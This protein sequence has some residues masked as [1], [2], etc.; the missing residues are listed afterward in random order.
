MP[1]ANSDPTELLWMWRAGVEN[2]KTGRPAAS[3]TVLWEADARPRSCCLPQLQLFT[4]AGWKSGR[5]KDVVLRSCP[6]LF[7]PV[8]TLVGNVTALCSE[9]VTLHESPGGNRAIRKAGKRE[10]DFIPRDW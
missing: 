3:Q 5:E 1:N 10:E 9:P 4:H 8:R 7:G 2:T 6:C